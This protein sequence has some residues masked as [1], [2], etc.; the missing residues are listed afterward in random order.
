[1]AINQQQYAI[2][3][4]IQS[5]STTTADT[6]YTQ[7]TAGTVGVIF[8]ARNSGSRIEQIENITQGTSV[9][10]IH[11]LWICEGTP[12]PTISSITFA[13][14]TA[15]VTTASAHGLATGNFVTVQGAYPND[16]NMRNVAITVTGASTF[17]YTMTTTPTTNATTVGEFASTPTTPVYHL[18]REQTITA[19]TGSST[20]SAFRYSLSQATDGDILPLILQAGHSL[21]TTVSVTQTHALKTT[22]RGGHN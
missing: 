21:R 16:Y 19:I 22:A 1:M 18:W 13:T 3:P 15:T 2:T 8:Q 12:G 20:V 17:T 11:R 6:S 10:G 7:P 5:G 4:A 9:A 14:T